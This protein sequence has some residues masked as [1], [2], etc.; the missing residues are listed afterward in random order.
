MALTTYADVQAKIARELWDRDDLT[1][2]I[3]DGIALLEA[4]LNSTLRV[5]QMEQSATITLTS[6]SGPLPADYLEWRRVIAQANPTRWL[7]WAEPGWAEDYYYA[8][9]TASAPSDHFTI[10]DGTIKTYPTSPSNLTM[11]YYQKIPA[12][13]S[14]PAGNWITGRAPGLYIYGTLLH[15]A[16]FLDDDPRMETWGQL[17]SKIYQELKNADTGYRYARPRMRIRGCAP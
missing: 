16:P 5:A 15:M 12:L 9:G 2:D 6:G 17:F 10:I 7:E 8:W 1:N 11:Q 3:I 14:N 13:A 4:D